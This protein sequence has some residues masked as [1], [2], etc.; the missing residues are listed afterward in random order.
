MSEPGAAR[1]IEPKKQ[2]LFILEPG[3]GEYRHTFLPLE[4]SLIASGVSV[5]VG[6]HPEPGH[7]KELRVEFASAQDRARE[8]YAGNMDEAVLEHLLDSIPLSLFRGALSVIRLIEANMQDADDRIIL[9]GHSMGAAEIVIAAFLRPDLNIQKLILINPA[10]WTDK[11]DHPSPYLKGAEALNARKN[12]AFLAMLAEKW[13]A[14]DI[15]RRVSFTLFVAESIDSFFKT[16]SRKTRMQQAIVDGLRYLGERLMNGQI[17]AEAHG[18]ANFDALPYLDALHDLKGLSVDV[19]YDK[20]DSN[21]PA[22][23]IKGRVREQRGKRGWISLHSTKGFGHY[24][25]VKDP[26]YFVSLIQSILAS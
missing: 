19:V 23:L 7:V 1:E 10:A 16:A 21:F 3:V 8:L 18:A 5:V 13:R 4:E 12:N 17:F 20:D 24:G 26:E 9:A 22:R 25:P 14:I 11:R 15:F 6:E 2:P